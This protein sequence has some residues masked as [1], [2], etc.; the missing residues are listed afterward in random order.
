MNLLKPILIVAITFLIVPCSFGQPWDINKQDVLS[1]VEKYQQN[2]QSVDQLVVVLN[3]NDT[4][5]KAR[6]VALEK[7]NNKWKIRFNWMPASIGRNGFALP[8][9]KVEGDGKSPTGLFSLGQFIQT[10]EEDK[11]IDDTNHVDYNTYVKGATTATSFEHLHLSSIDYKYCTVIEYN[12]HPV[13]KGKGSAIFFHLADA[14]YAPTAGCVAIQEEDM[15]KILQ[16]LQP[17]LGK[18]ILMGNSNNLTG[19]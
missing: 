17:N 3:N 6:V 12:T 10:N 1:I 5:T 9:M 7:R 19:N 18:A 16:W 11:W 8:G 14:N 2:L 4:S 15:N 13:V